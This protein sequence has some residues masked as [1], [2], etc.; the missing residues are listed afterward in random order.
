MKL[1]ICNGKLAVHA[2]NC[3]ELKDVV[4]INHVIP[5]SS[6]IKG[7]L[8]AAL[9]SIPSRIFRMIQSRPFTYYLKTISQG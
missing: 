1:D 8:R 6:I 9:F 2:A 5:D 3:V 7:I 4:T